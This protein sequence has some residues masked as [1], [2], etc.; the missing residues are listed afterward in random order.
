MTTQTVAPTNRYT[1]ARM[2]RILDKVYLACGYAAAASILL[3]LLIILVQIA[4]RYSGHNI[5]GLTTYAGYMM[6]SSTFLGLSYALI[7]GAH[8]RIET[9]SKMLG[10]GQRYV[11]LLAF[12]LGTIIA[13]WFAYYAANMDFTSWSISDVSTDLDETPLWIPQF[14]M[15]LG[16]AIF[17]TAMAD[18]F[19]TLLLTGQY[20]VRSNFQSL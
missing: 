14:T 12:F 4:V 13:A 19:I 11:D 1:L 18:N 17:A 6:A 8:I 2:H 3:V 9:I 10:R 15:A 7:N 16:T 20:R 5:G